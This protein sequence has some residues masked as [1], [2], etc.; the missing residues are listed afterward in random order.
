LAVIA[1]NQDIKEEKAVNIGLELA[2]AI[3]GLERRNDMGFQFAVQECLHRIF[4]E[5][6]FV[7][8]GLGDVV[9]VENPGILFEPALRIDVS[10]VLQRESRNTLVVLLW[11]GVIT[12]QRL[13]FLDESSEYHINQTDINYIIL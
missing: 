13:Y 3:G 10:D 5:H 12:P 9:I 2:D 8:P 7:E 6:T 4:R 1:D 11:P